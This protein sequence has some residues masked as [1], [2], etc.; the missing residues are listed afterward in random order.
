MSV[1]LTEAAALIVAGRYAELEARAN[2]WV[3]ATPEAGLAWKA[4]SV[5]LSAQGK[6]A[7]EASIAAVRLLPQDPEARHNLALA[8]FRRGNAQLGA[9]QPE[10]A[11]ASYAQ[12]IQLQPELAAVH[13]NLG[14]ALRQLGRAPEALASLERAL[15]LEPGLAIAHANRADTLR[16]LGRSDEAVSHCRRALE[17]QPRM[18]SAHNSLGNILLDLGYAAEAVASYRQA[19]Q[20]QPQYPGA[21]VNLG[22]AL[23]QQGEGA[24][25]E[26]VV[27]E[28]LERQPQSAPALV[29]LAELA[30]DRGDFAA[31][32]A[33]F[34][35][36]Q[37]ADPGS[38]EALAGSAYLR[39]L[40]VA[41]EGWARHAESLAAGA[42]PR[43]ETYLR[44]ALGKYY[45]DVG[46]PAA[47]FR[48]LQRAHE[49]A[50][51]EGSGHDRQRVTQAVDALCASQGRDWLQGL[52]LA[53]ACLGAG[54][55]APRPVFILGMPRSGTSLV[56]QILASHRDVFGA[57]EL[58]FW[59]ARA[60]AVTDAS[61]AAVGAE[62]RQRLAALGGDAGYVIDKMPANFWH[63]G[64]IHAAL[65]DAKIIHVERHP[66]DTCL[67]IY[68]TNFRNAYGYAHDLLDLA[69]YYREYRRLMQH[70]RSVVP[71][72]VLLDISYEALV[73]DV[74]GEGVRM[75]QFLGLDWNQRSLQF[76]RTERR[77]LTSSKW[78]VRQKISRRSVGRWRPYSAWLGP[79]LE[80]AA[81]PS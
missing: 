51:A 26:G 39:R 80:L 47:A 63:I 56:E 24:A 46:D 40:T 79:L 61:L 37:E 75:A 44:F 14:N 35:S 32:E 9:G 33:C 16:E 34:R 77:V 59:G 8:W 2:V 72:D 65:P 38:A 20:L 6:D 55:C 70:W 66:I 42:T 53:G 25:A 73:D 71:A 58:N 22:L 67:S 5:A 21:E 60:A 13:C 78:Q 4:L 28:L 29:L 30:S 43:K 11:A 45:D 12:T 36:A 1:D 54:A 19:L 81:S 15:E 18:A 69:H 62:Y 64:L 3:A 7:L 10:A 49:L 31:A 48:S 41:D 76:E 57:G 27:R 74:Q 23:R 68:F 52:R 50:Q 17:L